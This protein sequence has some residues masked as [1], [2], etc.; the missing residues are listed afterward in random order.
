MTGEYSFR[1]LDTVEVQELKDNGDLSPPNF[2]LPHPS[3]F[4]EFLMSI[5]TAHAV[6]LPEV[7]PQ[8]T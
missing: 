7:F 4:K 6:T 8:S 3:K 5:L 2:Y 1:I